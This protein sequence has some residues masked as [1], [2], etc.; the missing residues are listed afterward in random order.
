MYL[1]HQFNCGRET[2]ELLLDKN[3]HT[4]VLTLKH[5]KSKKIL[6]CG[7]C[8]ATLQDWVNLVTMKMVVHSLKDK[9]TYYRLHIHILQT[10]L[11][12][13]LHTTLTILHK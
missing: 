7:R 3:K 6:V 13:L 10:T 2:S 8:K 4:I 1:F 9:V 5:L 11:A 12:S